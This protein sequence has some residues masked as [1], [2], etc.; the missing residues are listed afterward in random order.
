VNR[1]YFARPIQS[2]RLS[3]GYGNTQ[4]ARDDFNPKRG[5]IRL[6]LLI[7]GLIIVGTIGVAALPN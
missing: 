5:T 6:F 2:D 4:L 3:H 1:D 7:V